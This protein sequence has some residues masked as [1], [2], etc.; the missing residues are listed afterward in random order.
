[1]ASSGP[2]APPLR[3]VQWATGTIG[4]RALRAVIE[5]PG[6]ELVGVHVHDA[7]KAGRDAGELCGLETV[8]GVRATR[9][10]GDVLALSADCVLYLPATGDPDEL[11]RLLESGAN[12]VTTTGEFHHPASLDPGLRRRVVAAGERGGSTVH[13]TRTSPGFVTEAVPLT[14]AS[15]Q[16]R[17]DALVVEEYAD[18]SRRPS[19]ELLFG[20]MGF[21]APPGEIDVRRFAH[22]AQ[23]FGPSL[24][25]V[26]DALGVP[27]DGVES[28]GELAVAARRTEIAAGVL[29]A[30]TVAAQRMTVTGIRAGRPFLSFRPTWYCTTD[31]DPAWDVRATGWHVRVDGDAP[32]EVDLRFP[33]PLERM[34][35]VSPG[36]TA[37]RAVNAVP[38]VC[39]A[40][41]GIRTTVDLPLVTAVLG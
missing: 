14:L 38:A 24:R 16:R 33:V 7:A 12:V 34:A 31:L 37:N 17:L 39:A 26:A 35:A 1:V 29:P 10:I 20:R 6:L 22:G 21:G 8:T 19:P 40:A 28:T 11:C 18:L 13:S 36:Y 32:L 5:H 9:E 41:P 15:V 25:L 2:A 23:S 27:L 30:G 4:A 3:V